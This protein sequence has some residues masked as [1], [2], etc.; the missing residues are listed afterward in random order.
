MNKILSS[1]LA[2]LVS[3]GL[4]AQCTNL[5]FS[6]YMEGSSNNKAL[7]IYNPTSGTVNLTGY[8]VVHYNNGS[9][10]PTYTFNLNGSI[11]AGGTYVIV[12]N[13]AAAQ[14]K[15]LADTNTTNQVMTFNGNDVLE[16]MQGTDTLDRIGEI[17]LNAN[18]QFDTTT[19]L[20]RSYVRKASIQQGTK[21]WS[22][23]RLQWNVFPRDTAHL[24]S[25]TMDPCGAIT[26]T[27]VRFNPTA[28]A[29]S[30]AA[31][32]Y[33]LN[34]V[35]NTASST[36]SFTV[37]VELVGGTGTAADVGNYTTQ[38]V[39]FQTGSST[40][41]LPI[42]ITDDTDAE[43]TETLVFRLTNATAPLLIG[44]DSIFTLTI[45]ASDVPVLSYTISQITSLDTA[46]VP[47]SVGAK[48]RV[49]GT[50]LGINYRATG[51]E[52]FIHDATDGIQV[53]SPSN[54]FGYTVTQGDS[55]LVEGEV[56]FFNGVTQIRFVDTLYKIGTGIVPVPT[57]VQDLGENTEAELV[58]LNNVNLVTPAQWTGSGSS[59][60]SCDITDGQNTWTLR[61]DEQCALYSQPAP[62]G[63]FDV[64]GI[65]SQFDASSPYNSGYQLLPRFT[66]DIVAVV[67]IK[68][69]MALQAMVYPNPSAGDFTIRT[70]EQG[71]MQVTITD[72]TGKVVYSTTSLETEHKLS[73][74]AVKGIYFANVL[75]NGKTFRS[76]LVVE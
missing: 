76:K 2:L 55:I 7:E 46:F 8:K 16:L 29:V 49:T 39:T 44:A 73:L 59:G 53:F 47:D 68:E 6:E 41:T 27:T 69:S 10:T 36:T 22:V 18:I 63:K 23:G 52:F 1:L 61:I 51:A 12:N 26:D 5:F 65:G 19:G 35:L 70:S 60:F 21:D 25:H 40:A 67:G 15:A 42:T 50:V 75:Q 13:G 37:D 43:P 71:E 14:Y 38:T 66:T 48:V 17:G 72:V 62:I 34:L 4:H 45:G 24:K 11:A 74:L 28:D 9:V 32:T 58:R 64:I 20:D 31:G 57:V 30:E 56:G 33:T 54:N 3:A